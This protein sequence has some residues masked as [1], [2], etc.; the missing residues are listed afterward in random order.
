MSPLFKRTKLYR[1]FAPSANETQRRVEWKNKSSTDGGKQMITTQFIKMF[2]KLK[3][4][5]IVMARAVNTQTVGFN[6]WC[7]RM[8]NGSTVTAADVAAVMQQ[9][10]DKLPEIL[11]LN[12]KVIC[13]PGGL[14]FRPKVS[15]SITQSQLKAK[16]E[17]RKASETDPEKAA[18]IN[19]NRALSTSDLSIGDCVATIE[20]DLPKDWSDTFRKRAEL[21]RVAKVTSEMPESPDSTDDNNGPSSSNGSSSGSSGS[22]G[23]SSSSSSSSVAA[24]TISG[25]M[26]F[27]ESTQVTMT[28]ESGAEIHYTTDGSTPTASSTLY[29][30]ALTLSDTTTVKAIAIKNG[31]SSSVSSK[32]FTKSSGG[33]GNGPSE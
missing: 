2:N 9:I 3:N 27:A 16:L 7:I 8:A 28:A 4:E 15:G 25:M 18:L 19:V 1:T 31:I 20:V 21:K 22:S 17:A 23:S 32:T 5:P 10:E 24:P 6:E 26:S 29:S 11:S 30:E 13:S 12:A 14:T 33:N